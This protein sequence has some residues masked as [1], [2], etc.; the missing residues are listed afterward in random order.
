MSSLFYGLQIARSALTASQ[1]GIN[2]TGH[3]ISN[4]NTT[5]YTRQRLVVESVQPST[6]AVRISPV[7]KGAVG[8]GVDV[9]AIEQV[10]SDYLDRQYRNQSAKLGYWQTRADEMEYVESVVNELSEDSSLSSAIDDFFN[11]LNDLVDDP[12][13]EEIRT[14]VRQNALKMTDTFQLRYDQLVELQSL[15]NDTMKLTV[16]E[17]NTKLQ[18]IAA[19]NEQIR[20][21]ELTGEKANELRDSRNLLI[22][23][24]SQLIN[25]KATE[26]PEGSVTISC[27]GTELLNY[28]TVTKLDARPELTGV[29]SGEPGHY[30]IYV[31]SSSTVLSYSSGK[32]K[33]LKDMRDGDSLN[34]V[35]LPYVLES[36]NTL[37]QSI[38]KEFNAVHSAGF[39][40]ATATMTSKTGINLFEVPAGGYG[41]ITARNFSLSS[42]VMD[43][44]FNIAASSKQIDLS[45][46]NTQEGN[47]ETA[48]AMVA[49]S[50]STGIPVV[51]NFANYL[52]SKV[53]EVG[54]VSST[55]ASTFDSQ[56]VI[57][58]NL[59]DR[60]LSISGVSLDEEMVNLVSY[61]HS[62]SAA[63]RIFTAID[64]ALDVL[65]NRT[66]RVG[67]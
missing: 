18:N 25:I 58:D 64:E 66:G 3:N 28:T 36:L 30:Q 54:S 42:E 10:R 17:I 55:A 33:A 57:M 19:F 32:L 34:N 24:L 11:S 59:S 4:A 26:T 22:D 43:S 23:D 27:E 56:T 15:Y 62:Y 37:A 45:A 13:S 60:R 8:A 63:A 61:Q 31:G 47:N 12:V 5:G 50:T 51:G 46:S 40:M 1:K 2:L 35:G 14:T 9:K 20:A 67:T 52:H 6:T 49:L 65:I 21:Y 29:G 48:L 53:V 44:V 38:A 39:T 41:D 7:E 16:D